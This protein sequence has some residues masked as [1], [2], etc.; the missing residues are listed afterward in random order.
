MGKINKQILKDLTNHGSKISFARK[1]QSIGYERCAELPLII[2]KIEPFFSKKISYLDIGSGTSILPS[3]IFK[4]TNWDITCLDKFNWVKNQEKYIK[5]FSDNSSDLNRFKIIIEDINKSNLKPETY[6]IITNISVVE[7]FEGQTDSE[8]MKKTFKLLK[9]GG[10]YIL[11]T[12]INE[13][14]FNEFYIKKNVYG[15]K[16]GGK[17]VFFQRHYDTDSFNKRLLRIINLE[18]LE[19]IFIGEYGFQ[20]YEKFLNIP[21]PFKPIKLFY[22]W[23]NPYFARNFISYR[24]YPVS[25]K[26]MHMYTSSCIFVHLKKPL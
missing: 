4:K 25:R 8:M 7:H 24:E 20:F 12:L 6:D 17:P 26:D 11:T 21:W 18:E 13:N 3:Y 16:Y 5:K 9:P 19:R 1:F 22:Q 15:E 2:S 23:A 14:F 10:S